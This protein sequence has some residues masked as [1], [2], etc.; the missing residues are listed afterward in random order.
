[1][2]YTKS[3]GASF[4]SH[5]QFITGDAFTALA[6]HERGLILE[7]FNEIS[8]ALDYYHTALSIL[9]DLSRS[10]HRIKS[11]NRTNNQIKTTAWR[12]AKKRLVT[13]LNRS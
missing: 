10:Q 12:K 8:L 7:E 5:E 2:R 6:Y 11:L 13:F 9:P 1:L 3:Y 4:I